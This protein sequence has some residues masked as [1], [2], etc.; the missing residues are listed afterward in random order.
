MTSF[1]DDVLSTLGRVTAVLDDLEVS[2]AVGGSLSSSV[3]GEPR[4]TNDIDIVAL[5]R[6]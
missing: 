1:A 4:S 6:P 5:L 3:H 2:W